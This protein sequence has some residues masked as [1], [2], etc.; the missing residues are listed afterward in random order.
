MGLDDFGEM[1]LVMVDVIGIVES[2]LNLVFLVSFPCWM[3]AFSGYCLWFYFVFGYFDF[4]VWVWVFLGLWFDDF[5]FRFY[6]ECLV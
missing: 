4:G 3:S 2:W 1:G 6:V 5:G